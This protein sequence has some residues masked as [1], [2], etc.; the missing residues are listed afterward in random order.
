F[1]VARKVLRA[2]VDRAILL[3]ETWTTHANEGSELVDLLFGAADLLREHL[4]KLRDSLLARHFLFLSVLPA[5]GIPDGCLR[6][7]LGTPELQVDDAGADIGPADI[8]SENG[9]VTFEHP[10]R[11]K[12]RCADQ[13]RIVGIVTDRHQI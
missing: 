2:P 9:V 3:N 5:F 4:H 10:G 11:R 1:P 13:A 7:V 6:K 12:V 8:D